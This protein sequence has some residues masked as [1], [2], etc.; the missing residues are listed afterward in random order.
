MNW[1][2]PHP[3]KPTASARLDMLRLLMVAQVAFGHYAQIGY[4]PIPAL[5]LH[6]M[7]DLF[8]AVYRLVIRFGG[9]AAFVF[10]CISGFFLVPRLIAA[11]LRVPEAEPIGQFLRRRLRRIY[12]TLVVAVVLTLVC[13]QIG[14]GWLG[15]EEFYRRF[16]AYDAVAALNWR[17]AL[18][19]LL[20][21]Q[22]NWSG[23]FGSNGPLWTLGYIVQFYGVGAALAALF[24]RSA[25]L[26][27]AV[28]G[29]VFLFALLTAPIWVL[30]FGCWLGCALIRW[31]K[32][33]AKRGAWACLAGGVI[34]FVAANRMP[35]PLG[36]VAC[37]LASGLWLHALNGA[38]PQGRLM[39]MPLLLE[40]L[41]SASYALYAFHYPLAVLAFVVAAPFV[42]PDGLLFRVIWPMMAFLL[43]VVVAIPWQGV[44][45]RLFG[46]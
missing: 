21:L 8:V 45:R 37:G 17:S 31:S 38:L 28:T 39:R 16:G 23:A 30:V 12:P 43:A 25:V 6:K 22:P 5:D 29:G 7:S 11:G 42:D 10:I 20:S 26:A 32:P 40:R 13:D 35:V 14:V 3:F 18:G 36:I 41:N 46:A 2:P 15:A 44:S 1:R 9:Q 27:L 34:L 24:R 4:P 19:N 33:P